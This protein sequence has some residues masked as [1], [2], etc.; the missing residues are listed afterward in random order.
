MSRK[1]NPPK[2]PKEKA[3]DAIRG[4]KQDEAVSC[5]EQ[6]HSSFKPLH[7]RY[8]DMVSLLLTYIGQKLGEEAVYEATCLFVHE[9]YPPVIGQ[10]KGASHEQ[11]VEAICRMHTTHYTEFH[12]I[13]DDEKTTVM[14]TGCSSGG[15]RLLRDGQPPLAKREGVT[16][17]AWPWSFNRIGFPYYC[18]HA[19]VFNDIFRELGLPMEVQWGRQYDDEGKPIDE[20]CK[21]LIFREKTK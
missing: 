13:E 2:G 5:V 1:T 19:Y 6:V 7:D 9:I 11:L 18:V 10:L 8:C 15:G 17:R 14:I 4:G 3:I 20:P 16:R 21:Y 12:L